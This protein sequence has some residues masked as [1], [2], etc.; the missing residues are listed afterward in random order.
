MKVKY[1]DSRDNLWC[2]ECKRRINLGVKY[3]E[4][5]EEYSGG[6]IIKEMHLPCIPAE[7]EDLIAENLD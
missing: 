7:E 4:V 6:K 2:S 1:N 5:E 3:A